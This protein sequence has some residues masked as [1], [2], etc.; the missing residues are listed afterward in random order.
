M[1][2]NEKWRTKGFSRLTKMIFIFYELNKYESSGKTQMKN[3][4]V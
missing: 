3:I 4:N 1:K 2:T